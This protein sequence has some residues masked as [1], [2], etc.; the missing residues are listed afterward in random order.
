MNRTDLLLNTDRKSLKFSMD[1][2][3]VLMLPHLPG[4][5]TVLFTRRIILI[6]QSID[7]L[8]AFKGNKKNGKKDEDVTSPSPNF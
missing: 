5:K 3:K 4:A 8:G 2:Q 1:K 6:N 7:P